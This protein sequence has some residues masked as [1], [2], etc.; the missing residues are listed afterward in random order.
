[1]EQQLIMSVVLPA[2]IAAAVVGAVALW[3]RREAVPAWAGALGIGAG[4]AVVYGF[5]AGW[6]AFAPRERWQWII[7]LA[8]AAA[9]A[10]ALLP[11]AGK[12]PA[13]TALA[14]VA[15]AA[16]AGGL[17]AGPGLDGAI[18]RAGLGATVLAL[19]AVLRPLT[20]GERPAV[21]TA[22]LAI[23]GATSAFVLFES[24]NAKLSMLAAALTSMAVAV[25]IVTLLARRATL[26]GGVAVYAAVVP[27]LLILGWAYD[28]GDVPRV[29]FVL[30]AVA[31]AALLIARALPRAW[32]K[33]WR[34]DVVGLALVAVM[35]GV[36]AALVVLSGEDAASADDPY[37]DLY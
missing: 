25:T 7:V 36:A 9:V 3:R 10:G 37:A 8:G 26:G 27:A 15:I 17:I 5:E 2:V 18:A 11:A 30:P 21:P 1:M 19:F 13:V 29:S 23:V 12:R 35:C 31:P 4:F 32:R 16:A 28:Y 33:G 34:G 24:H 22:A 20:G 14:G 6:S